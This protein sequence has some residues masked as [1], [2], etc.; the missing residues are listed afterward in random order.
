MTEA[1]ALAVDTDVFAAASPAEPFCLLA[2]TR[3]GL[4]TVELPGIA[5]A[6]TAL[7]AVETP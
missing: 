5:A 2:A 3:H 7:R 1:S 6:L 4:G